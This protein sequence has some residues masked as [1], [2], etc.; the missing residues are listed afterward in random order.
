MSCPSIVRVAGPKDFDAVWNLMLM[1][2]EENAV[3]PLS[4]N[5]AK[6][7]LRRAIFPEEI[8]PQDVGVRGVV[9]VIGPKEGIEGLVF[10]TIG[11][12]WYSDALH[13]EEFMVF[14]H[15][16]HRKSDHAKALINWMKTQVDET[17]LPLMT[18]IFSLK[19]T[20]AKCRLYQRMLP[21]LGELFY[22]TPKDSTISTA[23]VASSS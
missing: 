21:K 3:F 12:F 2:Y 6:W 1:S 9:G 13:L 10:L 7:F 8:P 17:G 4:E 5:K 23:L 11:S 22:L 16:E 19:R 18:G 20:E 15:P 14:V